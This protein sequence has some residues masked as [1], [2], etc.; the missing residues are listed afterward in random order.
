MIRL[1]FSIAIL[2][3][4]LFTGC[5]SDQQKETKG[6]S[7]AKP[8]IVII[9]TDDQN[10]E[11][12]GAYGGN[13]YTPH[14]DN[15]AKEGIRFT[16]AYATTAI[17]TPARYGLMTGRFPSRSQGEGFTSQ[18]PEGVQTEVGFNTHIGQ[19]EENLARLMK[20]S[21]Y[22]TGVVGKWDFGAPKLNEN[23]KPFFLSL[24]QP[25]NWLNA[26]L[27]S[28]NQADPKSPEVTKI[29][30]TNHTR[31]QQYTKKLGFDY[32]DALY[33]LNPE[34][35]QNHALNIH[36]MEWVAEAAIN[37]MDQYKDVPFFLY[38]APT[39]HHIPHPQESLLQGDPRMTIAGYLDKAPDV[40]PA[41][42]GIVP[43]V[44][45]AG[46]PS[47]TA[48]CTWL[49]DAIG[50]VV[51]K[52]KDLGVYDNTM[53]ILMSDHQTLAKTSLYEGGVKT[54]LIISYPKVLDKNQT[55]EQLV[56][57]ID[58]TPTVLDVCEVEKTYQPNIDGKSLLPLLTNEVQSVHDALFF[59]Y[60]WTRAVRTKKW[61]YLA[62]R[63]SESSDE[64]RSKKGVLYHARSLEPMQHE[65]LLSHPN[66]WDPDQL[67]D[68]SIDAGETTNLAGDIKHQETLTKMKAELGNWLKT[69][70]NHPFGEF[71]E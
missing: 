63:Y 54:P 37:F 9:Y 64:L 55:N 30:K 68:L 56:Q 29:L 62:L 69:F 44:L 42:E 67:Y 49:D 66:Y 5:Q 47:E 53:I 35:W 11:H 52:L 65:V 1:G 46:Y 20:K 71:V 51:Q 15:L 4:L 26:W 34:M 12:I 21:G 16:Q 70:G 57:N 28:K 61:K 24:P 23:G 14:I 32:A 18:F 2:F 38:M 7:P 17:C 8:N 6:S 3:G 31:L 19:N 48:Y 50:A 10:Y 45:E 22:K 60:G 25:K 39:L 43:R 59:E 41:R 58:I 40:M 13:V 36:N 33:N 27:E